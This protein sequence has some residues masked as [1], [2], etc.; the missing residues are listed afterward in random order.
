MVMVAVMVIIIGMML[1]MGLLIV[2][3]LLGGFAP[4]DIDFIVVRMRRI[5]FI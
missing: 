5:D 4:L 3:G 2:F 1:V